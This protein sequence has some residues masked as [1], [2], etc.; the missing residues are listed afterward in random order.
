ML[1]LAQA[2]S[3]YTK[4]EMSAGSGKQRNLSRLADPARA[5]C[6]CAE[7]RPQPS[8]HLHQHRLLNMQRV[9]IY[10]R[11]FRCESVCRGATV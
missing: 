11:K 10:L 1:S 2:A 9:Y 3:G 5:R 4:E 6:C 8:H 7:G